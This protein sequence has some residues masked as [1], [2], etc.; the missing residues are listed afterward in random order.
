MAK[1]H[2]NVTNLIYL[3][4]YD[5]FIVSWSS[6][7]FGRQVSI[8]RR[9]YTGIFWCELCAVVDVGWLQVVGRPVDPQL[10]TSQQA[11]VHATHTKNCQYSASWKWTLDARNM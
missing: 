9:H 8:L 11:Q 10:A 1:Y 5:H 3:H 4:F 6:T 7:W 2:N